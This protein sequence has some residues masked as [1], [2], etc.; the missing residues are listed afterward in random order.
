MV[1]SGI[2]ASNGILVKDAKGL[3]LL[4]KVDTFVVDK[5]GTLTQGKPVV[6]EIRGVHDNSQAALTRFQ[7]LAAAVESKSEHPLAQAVVVWAKEKAAL[8]KDFVKMQERMTVT[9]FKAEIGRGVTGRVNGMQVAVGKPELMEEL[10]LET[11]YLDDDI[12]ELENAGDTVVMLSVE[13]SIEGLIAMRDAIKPTASDTISWLLSKGK[14]I[15]MIT[16][17][18]ERT[19]RAIAKEANIKNIMAGVLPKN[20]AKKIKELQDKNGLVAMIG[21]GI[22]DAPAL[23]V[24]D[25]G[26]AMGTGTDIAIAS[27]DITLVG[28]Q[29]DLLKRAISLS[30]A[31]MTIIRQNLFW[32]FAYNILLIPVAAGILYLPFNLLV[33]PMLASAAM[34]FSSLS[35][36]LNSLRLKKAKL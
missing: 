24:A 15:W 22:N 34:A 21:D 29:F 16:G 36:V 9:D 8:D 32:A 23:A 5:T 31:T 20:K 11:K 7:A 12:K 25:V 30:S 3:E 35:V 17:D 10:G 6:K 1:G 27:S 26:I 13:G 33:N 14:N 19:A 2:G 18:N 4:S 28:E